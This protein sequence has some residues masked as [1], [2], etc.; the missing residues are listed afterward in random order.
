VHAVLQSRAVAI[1]SVVAQLR[2]D[3]HVITS[4]QPVEPSLEDVFLDLVERTGR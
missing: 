4:V 1:D 3:G 2:A